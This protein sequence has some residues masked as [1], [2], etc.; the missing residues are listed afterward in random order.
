[1][2]KARIERESKPEWTIEFDLGQYPDC[3]TMETEPEIVV[4]EGVALYV[5]PEQNTTVYVPVEASK[6]TYRPAKPA[7]AEPEYSKGEEP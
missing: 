2:E 5:I 6:L 4:R 7:E 1:M 3:Y